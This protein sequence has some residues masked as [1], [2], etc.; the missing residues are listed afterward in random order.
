[1]EERF[2]KV[3]DTSPDAITISD[4]SKGGYIDVN[5][6]FC[7]QTG[8][9]KAEV[10]GKDSY[11]IN[12]WVNP[13]D[14]DLL[15][16]GLRE[17]G[18][19][20]N[21][22]VQ[23]R[24]KNGTIRTSLLSAV[25]LD[26]DGVP[27]VLSITRDITERLQAIKAAD[28]RREWINTIYRSINDAIFVHPYMGTSFGYFTEVNEVA[29]KRYGYT[30]EEFLTMGPKDIVH[31]DKFKE[32]AKQ[33]LGG[34]KNKKAGLTFETI[35]VKKSG[36]G[37]PVEINTGLIEQS[38]GTYILAVV[39]D[40]SERKKAEE[41]IK[42]GIDELARLYR[43]S[44]A[45]LPSRSPDLEPLAQAIV[46]AILVEFDHTNCSLILVESEQE[47]LNRVAVGGPY[48]MEVRQGKLSLHGK[49]LVPKAIR[50]ERIINI[51][52]VT[53]DMDYIP[54]WKKARSELVVP[55]MIEEQVIGVLD[56]QSEKVNAFSED[57]ERLMSLFVKR[58]ALAVH[59][60]RLYRDAKRRLERL[61]AL[62]N[63]DQ[64]ITG[65]LDLN[66]TLEIV[67]A[68]IILQLDVDAADIL[69]YQNE[70]Q[71]LRYAAGSGFRSQTFQYTKLRL[72]V[73]CAGKAAL[74]RRIIHLEN[75][76]EEKHDFCFSPSFY[77]EEFVEYFGV[78]LISKGKVIG[79]LEIFNRKP[80]YPDA[81]WMSFM[82]T[83]AGQAA[84]AID[85]INM[86]SKLQI[87]NMELIHAYDSTIEGW[88]HAL[89]LRDM[90]TEGHSRRV[91]ELT[92]NIARLMGV[93][94]QELL[95]IRRGALLHDIGKIGVPDRILQKPGP[96][97]EE[98]W[99]V[100]REHPEYA[101]RLL[102]P[103]QYLKPAL[104]IPYSH[105]ERW[106]GSGYPRGLKGEE[107]PIAARIFAIVDV[108]DALL[109]NR[110][111]R[112]A[113]PEEKV[114]NYLLEQSGKEFDP[115]IVAVFVNYLQQQDQH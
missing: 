83:L 21:Q 75:L 7:E 71:Q 70:F 112:N 37:F 13:E 55:L 1:M 52:D 35:H 66:I 94:D 74:E 113:W 24:M 50:S 115:E 63:I 29:C 67:V 60:A 96:L 78:P 91:V 22:E 90:E 61:S 32:L 45:L 99:A 62:R 92:L 108:W 57:D 105:H 104:D 110:P 56:V 53:L 2:R 98:E 27:C 6:G 28:E 34:L 111:Y 16:K 38:D 47:L 77:E 80:A 88:A 46:E 44:S 97:S 106:D 65:N 73:G 79:V 86:F 40:I 54:N 59:S 81:E 9:T 43:A 76:K 39:R 19:V 87:S 51:P 20:R 93:N 100:M 89:E 84:I 68:Q 101:Y 33:V 12:I 23:F 18:E 95:H 11:D 26:M 85:N 41:K 3:F 31:P 69:L 14:R 58:A 64:A 82:D 30:R 17:N 48:A 107:I 72:G 15:G 36:E 114:I 25:I 109:S 10:I 4:L 42:H 49:G 103:I 8:Y 102:S 5:Q